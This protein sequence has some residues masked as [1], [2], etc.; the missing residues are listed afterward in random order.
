[1]TNAYKSGDLDPAIGL[2]STLTGSA[3]SG[4]LSSGIGRAF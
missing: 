1:M 4:G 2:F 3:L